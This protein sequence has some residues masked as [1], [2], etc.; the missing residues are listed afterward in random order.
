MGT[1]NKSGLV[2]SVVKTRKKKNRKVNYQVVLL[3][4]NERC[5]AGTD[6]TNDGSQN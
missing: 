5:A 6:D 2:L 3:P 4:D 1:L